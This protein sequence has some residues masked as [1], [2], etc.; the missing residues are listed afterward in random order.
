MPNF[1]SCV[2]FF[3]QHD[4]STL[5]ILRRILFVSR[6]TVTILKRKSRMYLGLLCSAAQS[7]GSFRVTAISRCSPRWA[8]E[9]RVRPALSVYPVFIPTQPSYCQSSL[10]WL[11]KLRPSMVMD[12]VATIR[13]RISLSITT[14]ASFAMSA[15]V[16]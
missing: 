10:L 9:T 7:L 1:S 11:V 5:A 13:A 12:F 4:T 14:R 16:E 3:L 8:Q 2:I 6:L 15:A